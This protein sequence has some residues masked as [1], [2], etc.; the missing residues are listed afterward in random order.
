MKK[1]MIE[2]ET[3]FC[4]DFPEIVGTEIVEAETEEEAR[5][6][7]KQYHAVIMKVEEIIYH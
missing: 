2:W 3:D 7:I 1:F 6:Q 5:K 4:D